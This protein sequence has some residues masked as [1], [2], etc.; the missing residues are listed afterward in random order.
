MMEG[1][2]LAAHD[3]ACRR[4]DRVLFRGL[5]FELGAGEALHLAMR[6][7]DEGFELAAFADDGRQVTAASAAI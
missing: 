7:R 6:A 1:A 3:I 2:R 4:G 5:S